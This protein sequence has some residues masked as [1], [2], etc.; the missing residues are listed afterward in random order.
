MSPPSTSTSTHPIKKKLFYGYNR[1]IQFIYFFKYSPINAF[2]S[3]LFFPARHGVP[4]GLGV[5]I[6]NPFNGKDK[7]KLPRQFEGA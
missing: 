7:K 5:T 1:K 6:I 4:R 2:L 3:F